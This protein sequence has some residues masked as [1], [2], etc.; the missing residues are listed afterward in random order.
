MKLHPN[1]LKRLPMRDCTVNVS[2]RTKSN[3]YKKKK[4]TIVTIKTIT[5]N[6][7]KNNV[8]TAV[9]T[10]TN[11]HLHSNE[12]DICVRHISVPGVCELDISLF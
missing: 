2:H 10:L 12:I 11:I 4:Y 1:L 3:K 9:I 5:I 8:F 6:S 7:D